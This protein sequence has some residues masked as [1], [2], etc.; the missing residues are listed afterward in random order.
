MNS[1]LFSTDT[2]S[3]CICPYLPDPDG[4]PV[5]KPIPTGKFN[6]SYFVNLDGREFVLR[7]APPK[8]SVFVF[9]ERDMML[10][11]PGI[12]RLLLQ[13]TTV[14]VAKIL[15]FDDSHE[16]IERNFIL[17]ERL[18]GQPLSTSFFVDQNRVLRQVG[19]ALAQ[20]HRLTAEQYGYLGEHAPMLPQ[21]TW[22]EAFQVMWH[23]LIEDVAA[24][25]YYSDEECSQLRDLLDKHLSLFDR[26]VSA[27]LLHMDVWGQNIL[28]DNSGNLTGL[29]DW[30][31][32]LWG[33]PEI[34][35]AVLDYCGVSQP[36]FWE[37]Y[38]QE[39]DYS[40]AAQVRN[41]FYLLYELQKYIVIRHGRNH[42]PASAR[43]Y[44]NQV[45]QI[46]RRYF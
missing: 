20:T 8:D 34:E 43:Q 31:R 24:V 46:V 23:K 15:A 17:M 30:D 37:G 2:L 42:D 6:T 45:V 7:I 29:V 38:G 40:K 16:V 26:K 39:R 3:S 41:L 28:I 19:E 11:E 27:S 10:Q 9:Y 32:A 13:E 21:S 18:P 22:I 4:T 36:A 33:D 35:F 1:Q 5:F 12:H 25:R 44:K 14:P